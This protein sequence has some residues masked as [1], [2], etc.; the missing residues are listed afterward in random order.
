MSPS[1]ASA[2]KPASPQVRQVRYDRLTAIFPIAVP[3]ERGRSPLPRVRRPQEDVIFFDRDDPR[4]HGPGE[5]FAEKVLT[6]RERERLA[7]VEH[8]AVRR[9]QPEWQHLAR[10]GD[11]PL[12]G[13]PFRVGFASN[14]QWGH[15]C[16]L[17]GVQN[18]QLRKPKGGCQNQ[19]GHPNARSTY[20]LIGLSTFGRFR[21]AFLS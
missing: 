8:A 12:V 9:R 19:V 21:S 5:R 18:D 1:T 10:L 15:P 13:L 20:W 6:F 2:G 17:V 3:T 7:G 16:L 4:L 14:R 11:R